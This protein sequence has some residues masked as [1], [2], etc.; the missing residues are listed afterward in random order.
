[1]ITTLLVDNHRKIKTNLLDSLDLFVDMFKV[2]SSNESISKSDFSLKV[3]KPYE[4]LLKENIYPLVEKFFNQYLAITYN[5]VCWFHQYQKNDFFNWHGHDPYCM[6]GVYYIE[7][8]A[9]AGT[10]F[11]NL[12]YTAKEGTIAIFPGWLPHRSPIN[13]SDQRKT[14]ISFNFMV[15][16][17]IAKVKALKTV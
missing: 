3:D 14:I 15:T 4:Y 7:L 2:K 9:G 12:E 16:T 5:H 13:R 6:V 17:D 8:P 11:Y 10:E 1:M